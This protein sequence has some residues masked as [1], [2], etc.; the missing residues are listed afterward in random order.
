M[1]AE[2]LGNLESSPKKTSDAIPNPENPSQDMSSISSELKKILPDSIDHKKIMFQPINAQIS[3]IDS[4]YN[5]ATEVSSLSNNES[6]III[7]EIPQ[8][9]TKKKIV[10]TTKTLIKNG[11]ETTT[12]STKEEIIEENNEKDNNGN[13]MNN[14]EEII[15][16]NNNEINGENNN[17]INNIHDS[18]FQ[19]NVTFGAPEQNNNYNSMLTSSNVTFGVNNSNINNLNKNELKSHNSN[20]SDSNDKSSEQSNN[21]IIEIKKENENINDNNNI[22]VNFGFKGV[23]PS[24][25]KENQEIKLTENNI[26]FGFIPEKKIEKEKNDENE[27]ELEPGEIKYEIKIEKEQEKE[28][29][30]S[31]EPIFNKSLFDNSNNKN[32]QGQSSIFEQKLFK[33]VD[34]NNYKNNIEENSINLFPNNNNIT[35]SIFENNQNTQETFL[36]N[37]SSLIPSQNSEIP[38]AVFGTQNNPLEAQ[39]PQKTLNEIIKEGDVY[40]ADSAQKTQANPTINMIISSDNNNNNNENNDINTTTNII[41]NPILIQSMSKGKNPFKVEEPKNIEI[42]INS[43]NT[44]NNA[45]T[46]ETTL[47][48]FSIKMENDD[49][50]I[51]SPM[52]KLSFQDQSKWFIQGNNNINNEIK[53]NPIFTSFNNNY[54]NINPF[55]SI[56]NNNNNKKEPEENKNY[57]SSLFPGLEMMKTKS[58]SSTQNKNEKK[59]R[60]NPIFPGASNNDLDV[61]KSK[62]NLFVNDSNKKEEEKEKEKEKENPKEESQFFSEVISIGIPPVNI[63]QIKPEEKKEEKKE[64]NKEEKKEEKK[65]NKDK[66]EENS[67]VFFSEV[68]SIGIPPE[69][70]NQNKPEEKK[71]ENKEDNSKKDNN[72]PQE[73][74]SD[75]KENENPIDSGLTLSNILNSNLSMNNNTNNKNPEKEEK[76]EESEEQKNSLNENQQKPRKSLFGDLFTSQNN[77]INFDDIFSN[78]NQSS[79]LLNFNSDNGNNQG[80]IFGNNEK[81]KEKEKEKNIYANNQGK[82]IFKKD[83]NFELFGNKMTPIKSVNLYQNQNNLEYKENINN[84]S[85]EPKEEKDEEEISIDLK[86]E[87]GENDDNKKE[88]ESQAKKEV[89]NSL[90]NS[91]NNNMNSDNINNENNNSD[92]DSGNI[93]I[94]INTNKD[95]NI[96]KIIP[97]NK[98]EIN[99]VKNEEEALSED[100]KEYNPQEILN[101]E[102]IESISLPKQKP[103]NKKIYSDLIEKMYRITES[104]KNEIDIPEKKTVTLYDNTLSK[105][106]KDFEDKI[107]ELKNLYIIT[108]IKRYLEHD[109]KKQREIIIKANIPKKRN[110]L[111]KIYRNMMDVIKNKLQKENQKYYYILILKILDKYK[112][113]KIKEKKRHVKNYR[114]RK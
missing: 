35:N 113:I 93:I 25:N 41:T 85:Q 55:N 103:L 33:I 40:N 108:I 82:S 48:K 22:N 57:K 94:N 62:S 43:N 79:N 71:E 83:D 101:N 64:E 90:I 99:F 32:N 30:E 107:K 26:K 34:S 44:N 74:F 8:I 2:N 66:K 61:K 91:N 1:S 37:N 75:N 98:T 100:E 53:V 58:E 86:A 88:N 20:I 80:S 67:S 51:S 5:N 17:N 47:N 95:K 104:K 97:D 42:N 110:E 114:K 105:F 81:E 63:N 72:K 19:S 65:D 3:K 106:L 84:N 39:N 10:T 111:K 54:N 68:I 92:N 73:I 15:I 11:K 46:N 16:E 18:A 28:K 23:A 49:K 87:N 13:I 78:K 27:N 56:L 7:K 31:K 89:E 69:N 29:K 59:I 24:K 52:A 38:S 6:K 109:P 102:N 45:D 9:I 21:I 77:D 4:I 76:K 50:N 12:T 36:K 96:Q 14:I 70:I 112:K 60:S